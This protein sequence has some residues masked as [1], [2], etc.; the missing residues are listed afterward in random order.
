MFWFIVLLLVA[1]AGFYFYQ[2]MRTIER[3]IHAELESAKASIQ[4]VHEPEKKQVKVPET[5]V[6][7]SASHLATAVLATPAPT[8]LRGTILAEVTKRPGMKQTELYPLF[9]DTNKKQLQQLIK[10]LA[11]DGT[12]R[13]EKQGSTYLLYPV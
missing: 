9:V 3:E 12:L 8:T 13:R 7:N 4:P 11:D 6:L 10:D 2:K 5:A 1:G